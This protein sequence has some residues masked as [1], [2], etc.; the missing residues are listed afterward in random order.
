MPLQIPYETESFPPGSVRSGSANLSA[1]WDDLLWAAVTVGRPNTLYVFRH[2]DASRFEALFRWSILR[3]AVEQRRLAGRRLFRTEAAQSLDPTEKGAV[4]YFL[5]MTVCKLFAA[6]LL[7]TPWLLHLDVFGRGVRAVLRGRSRPDLIGQEQGT[8]RWHAFECKG[9]LSYPSATSKAN[10]KRQAQR[11][12][13]VAGAPCSLH[14]GAIT[15]FKRDVL[16]FYWRDP[17]PDSSDAIDIRLAPPW[18][19]YYAPIAAVLA[20]YTTERDESER[21]PLT[22]SVTN[23]DLEVSVHDSIR[24]P[25]LAGQWP[26][27]REIAGRLHSVFERE[28]YQPDG[29]RVK[30]GPTWSKPFESETAG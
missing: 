30:A 16:S 22:A 15:H 14:I 27:V 21:S 3:M 8:G 2:G 29:L 6:K 19:Y 4:N 26:A 9:R 11:L 7:S 25:F 1:T 18:H 17:H 5:G 23:L 28:G 20:E 13:S 24:K 10:A 12:V